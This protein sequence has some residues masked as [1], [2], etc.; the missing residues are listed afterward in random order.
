MK[1]IMKAMIESDRGC[2]AAGLSLA[3]LVVGCMTLTPIRAAYHMD[4]EPIADGRSYQIDQVDNGAVFAKEGLR[5][6]VRHLS[7]RELNA[8]YPDSSN[9]FTYRGEVDPKLGH[10]P[11][12]FTVFQVVLNNPTFDKVLLQP[13]DVFL[14]TDRGKIMRPYQLT[15]AE[16]R[17]D[18][19][20]F[21]TYWLSRGVQSGNKQKLYLE[22][23]GIL[24][25]ALYHRDAPVFKGRSYRG[26]LVFD[27]L[28]PDAREVN[29]HLDDL[30]LEFGIYDTPKDRVD[31]E[32]NFLVHGE[33]IEPEPAMAVV[34]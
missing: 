29:L 10:V 26:L 12:R 19:R 18:E 30:V 6:K 34:D 27:P 4:L 8:Q 23:M 14:R 20:N 15:R 17:G 24:R 31:L 2:L 25:G 5:L 16:A 9:P 21:E 32:F 33:I 1:P 13:E 7:D 3:V 28:A 22:R 11:M